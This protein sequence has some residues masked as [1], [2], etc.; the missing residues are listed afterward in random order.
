M[1]PSSLFFIT[2][3]QYKFEEFERLFKI[4]NVK[5]EHLKFEVSEIQNFDMELIIKDK[6]AKAYAKIFQ[7]IMVDHSSIS[8]KALNDLPQGLNHTYWEQLKDQVCDIAK[9]LNNNKAEIISHI[10]FCDGKRIYTVNFKQEGKIAI[11]PSTIGKFHLDR[12]F[13]PDGSNTILSEMTEEERDKCGYRMKAT[14]KAIELL[15]TIEL[16]KILGLKK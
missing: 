7:P 14:E 1:K 11:A 5:L 8:M 6:A 16:G 2:T 12:V 15:K 13:I 10:G 4:F 9:Q 3:N